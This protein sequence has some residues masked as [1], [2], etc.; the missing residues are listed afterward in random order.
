MKLVAEE[1]AQRLEENL[2]ELLERAKSG[3]YKAPPVRWVYISKSGSKT[4]KRPIG[5]PTFEDKVL[6]RAVVML[7]EPLCEQ[8]F[9]D[10]SYGFRPGRS[11]HGALQTLW[12]KVMKVGGGYLIDLDIRKFFDTMSHSHLRQIL[13][14]RVCHG[15]LTR[16]IGK[17]LKA[18][19]W[20]NGNVAYPQEGSPQG[21][22]CKAL[23][24]P[25][26]VVCNIRLGN[27]ARPDL[28]GRVVQHSV[29]SN[30]CIHY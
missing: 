14:A 7:L 23:H 27:A 17:W 8:D 21:S 10:C 18:G 2:S 1:Y 19:V 4:E 6:Q 24:K 11:A 12:E 9:L 26:Y 16:L 22:L 30:S 5:I 15:V 28:P 20:E 13:K 3:L 25:P 29:Y